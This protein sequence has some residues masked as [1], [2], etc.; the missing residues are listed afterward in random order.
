MPKSASALLLVPTIQMQV[1]EIKSN[2]PSIA[3]LL[4]GYR[5]LNEKCDLVLEKLSKKSQK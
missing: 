2:S 3:E 4:E 5:Q 1:E